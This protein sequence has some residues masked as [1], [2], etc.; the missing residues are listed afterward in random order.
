MGGTSTRRMG[1]L[2]HGIVPL[3][4]WCFITFQAGKG[5]FGFPWGTRISFT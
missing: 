5:G 1:W 3:I 2:S 4:A